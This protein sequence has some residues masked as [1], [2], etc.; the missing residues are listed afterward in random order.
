M[1]GLVLLR[2]VLLV[3]RVR[4]VVLVLLVL[5]APLILRQS[6]K[7]P[8]KDPRNLQKVLVLRLENTQQLLCV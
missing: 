4:L 6:S 1:T 3:L 8:S 7:A 5:L 2:L